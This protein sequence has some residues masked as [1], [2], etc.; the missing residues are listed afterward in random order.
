MKKLRLREGQGHW[1]MMEQDFHLDL[2]D[3]GAQSFSN[4]SLSLRILFCFIWF[5]EGEGGEQKNQK[6]CTKQWCFVSWKSLERGIFFSLKGGTESR[7]RCLL[8]GAALLVMEVG[9]VVETPC[10]SRKIGRVYIWGPAVLT[11]GERQWKEGVI[12]HFFLFCLIAFSRAA[13]ANE[14]VLLL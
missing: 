11:F 1:E 9:G 13:P 4:H 8:P 12:F 2:P 3:S 5:Q 6:E 10:A 7:S 14:H